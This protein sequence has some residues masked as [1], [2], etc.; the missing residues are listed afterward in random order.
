MMRM[1]ASARAKRRRQ[2]IEI[3]ATYSRLRYGDGWATWQT[4]SVDEPQDDQPYEEPVLASTI[5]QP[6]LNSLLVQARA[7]CSFIRRRRA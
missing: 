6:L 7:V 5:L 1:F 3:A 4:P 2:S